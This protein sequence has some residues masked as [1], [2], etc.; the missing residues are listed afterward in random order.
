M[1]KTARS[2]TLRGIRWVALRLIRALLGN[3]G[4]PP[5]ERGSGRFE[6]P[7]EKEGEGKNDVAKGAASYDL[8]TEVVSYLL[9][10]G[11]TVTWWHRS[12]DRRPAMAFRFGG[13][14]ADERAATWPL[15]PH[16]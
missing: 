1:A 11:Q 14:T 6:T 13:P 12:C 3:I 10:I 8:S 16:E 15:T 2:M 4:C 7:E 5:R 9:T